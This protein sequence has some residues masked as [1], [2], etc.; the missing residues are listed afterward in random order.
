MFKLTLKMLSLI[1]RAYGSCWRLFYHFIP[2]LLKLHDLKKKK[3][4]FMGIMPPK[5]RQYL[6]EKISLRCYFR[7]AVIF[8]LGKKIIVSKRHSSYQH[9]RKLFSIEKISTF[10]LN[11]DG[12]KKQSWCHNSFLQ[13]FPLQLKSPIN[14]TANV[15]YN[16][17]RLIR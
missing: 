5:R 10:P 14:W 12:W 7:I 1:P 6:L 17:Q 9:S 11:V 4:F 8:L 16:K 15:I 13:Y 3:D 2:F